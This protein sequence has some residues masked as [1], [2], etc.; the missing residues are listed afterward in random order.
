MSVMIKRLLNSLNVPT[1]LLIMLMLCAVF[2]RLEFLQESGK[3]FRTYEKAVQTFLSGRNPY[4]NT[5]QSFTTDDSGSHGYAYLPGILTLYSAFYMFTLTLGWSAAVLWKIPVLVA[6][7]LIGVYIYR[8]LKTK[9]IL[10][11][12]FGA[13]IW[14]FNSYLITEGKYTHTEPLSI[15]FLLL[16]LYYLNKDKVISYTSLALSVIFKTLPVILLPYLFFKGSK[17]DKKLLITICILLGFVFSLPFL[18]SFEDFTTMLKGSLFVHGGREVQG[19]PFL[20]YLSYYYGIELF[21]IIPLRVYSLLSIIGGV[22]ISLTFLVLK[23]GSVYLVTT[24]AFLNFY[25]FTPVFNRTYLLWAL[26]FYIIAVFEVFKNK[27]IAYV[28][29]LFYWFFFYWYLDQWV[30]GFHITKPDRLIDF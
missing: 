13:F 6:D 12:L 2:Y 19:R 15:L 9:T 7:L 3:D 5:L 20:F 1:V 22:V 11:A 28:F 17:H 4:I 16:S 8:Q 29:I 25:L 24:L 26:P 18:T 23:R 14:Y 30:D 27:K 21:Q 10:G